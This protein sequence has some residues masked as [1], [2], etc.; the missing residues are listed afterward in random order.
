[1]HISAS[2]KHEV[3]ALAAEIATQAGD[4]LDGFIAN[5]VLLAADRNNRNAAREV[6]R[7]E[8]PVWPDFESA[9]L[10]HVAESPLVFAVVLAGIGSEIE[11]ETLAR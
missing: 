9:G 3:A 8:E 1:M 10:N 4:T 11:L 5:A 2:D 7:L 6:L